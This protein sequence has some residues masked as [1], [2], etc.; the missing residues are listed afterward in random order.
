MTKTFQPIIKWSGSK[1][2]Q[3]HDI[4]SYFPSEIDTYYEPF[5]G[6]ASVLRELLESDIKVNEYVCSDINNGL[7]ELWK[8]IQVDPYSVAHVYKE[9][10]EELNMDND[11]DRQK[12][13]Y[14]KIRKRYNKE[15]SPLDFIFLDR[16]CFNGLIRYNSKGQFNSPFHINRPGIDPDK[17]HKIVYEWADIL[18][19]NNV[20]FKTMSYDE[21]QPNEGDFLY[22]DPPYN[23][24]TGMYFDKFDRRKFFKWLKDIKCG[25]VLSYDGKSGN[26]DNTYEVPKTLYDEHI[27][28]KSGNSS[29]KRIV[30]SDNNAMVYESLYIKR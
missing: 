26:T 14:D 12:K 15:K 28:L 25:W 11:I 27:Y 6:G 16:T 17:L 30:E 9:F 18:N 4:V 8:V 23:N 7:I 3:A 24:T 22:L 29:F 13:F 5:C 19:D 20:K 21:I 1:R 10:W 2:S